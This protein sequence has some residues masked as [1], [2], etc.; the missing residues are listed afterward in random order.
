MKRHMRRG[1]DS[2]TVSLVTV[3]DP[4]VGTRSTAPPPLSDGIEPV[5]PHRAIGVPVGSSVPSF[6]FR[7]CRALGVGGGDGAAADHIADNR[8]VD[9]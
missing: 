2:W 7:T 1:G 3:V 5:F 4:E 6:W 8:T 9:T